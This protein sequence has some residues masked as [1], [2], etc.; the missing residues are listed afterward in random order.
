MAGSRAPH[1]P[2]VHGSRA[3][4]LDGL[5]GHHFLKRLTII[6]LTLGNGDKWIASAR[7]RADD[8]RSMTRF[9]RT[10]GTF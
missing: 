10:V 8:H 2:Q 1:G 9:C 7:S 5:Q 3:G 4:A 6:D